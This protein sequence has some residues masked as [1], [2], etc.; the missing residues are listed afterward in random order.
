MEN[1]PVPFETAYAG[2]FNLPPLTRPD[3]P[4]E[5]G[6]V[7]ER[8]R[9]QDHWRAV[10]SEQLYGPMPDP[11]PLSVRRAPLTGEQAERLTLEMR[12]AD[13]RFSVDAALW[14]PPNRTGAVPLIC[15]LDF[16]GPI[17]V[18][19]G[20][21]FPLDSGATVHS[22]PELGAR[23]GRLAEVLRGTAAHRWPVKLML[24][25]GFAV[26]VSCYG[27]WVPDD[28]AR[29]TGHG[30]YPLLG[31]DRS[32]ARTGAISLWAWS[33]SRLIDA[34]SALGEV[35]TR[36][37]IVAGHSRLGKAAL[38]A[39]AHDTRIRAVFA[40]ASGCGGAAPARHPI[41][42]T[43]AQMRDRFPHWTVPESP[44]D[45]PAKL[46]FDQHALLSLVAPRALFLA[47]AEND[48]WA[49]PVGSYLALASAARVWDVEQGADNAPWPDPQ[50]MWQ[51]GRQIVR[52]RLGHHLRPGGH[53]MLPMDWRLFLNFVETLNLF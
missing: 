29:W 50:E 40:N 31:C 34:A 32:D 35:D 13:R 1:P 39:A 7:A 49:D 47:S 30:V 51:P 28:P 26:L 42:E 24:D 22:R 23:D 6:T 41:G 37:T 9:C 16:S 21:S 11:G 10:L 48:L 5:I 27:S 20:D 19:N 38:W 46:P 33:I 53:D 25:A 3:G 15:G 4:G 2:A 14:L 52:G 12:V 36:R 8:N 17:G 44:V 18:L 45:N 43:L